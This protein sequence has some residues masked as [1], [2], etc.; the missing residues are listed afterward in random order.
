MNFKRLAL[1]DIKIDIPRLA[2]KKVL[3]AAL[4][5]SGNNCLVHTPRHI[6]VHGSLY[7]VLA[8]KALLLSSAQMASARKSLQIFPTSCI[9]TMMMQ[10]DDNCVC[11][12]A[13]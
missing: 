5:E 12:R 7:N 1:T 13:V 11:R 3:T 6:S 9:D 10:L 8:S 2:K 4:E